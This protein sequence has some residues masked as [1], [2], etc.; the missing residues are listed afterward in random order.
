MAVLTTQHRNALPASTFAG[1]GRSFPIPDANHAKA[2]L[3]LVGRAEKHGS[4]TPSE[5]AHI[6]EV[7][8][9]KLLG[10]ALKAKKNG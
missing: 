9:R 2:A 3:S 10:K 1:P 4:V 6:R 5:A 8:H 7:A